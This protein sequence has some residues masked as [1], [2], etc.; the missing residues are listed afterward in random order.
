MSKLVKHLKDA[1]YDLIDGP[2]RNQDLLQLY[3]KR[4]A[5]KI[6]L[7]FDEMLQ[8]FDG[9][10]K[11]SVK[12]DNALSINS[13]MSVSYDFKAGMSAINDSLQAFKIG[14]VSLDAEIKKG[15]EV[16]IS[17]DSSITRVVPTGEI[18]QFLS[19]ARL[20]ASNDRFLKDMNQN[21]LIVVTG[22]V[23]AKNFV[24]EIK[25]ES[26]VNIDALVASAN[27]NGK[28]S[29]QRQSNNS[30]KM[31]SEGDSLIPIAIKANR[32]KFNKDKFSDLHLVSDSRDLFK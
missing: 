27:G 23:F 19:D 6:E 16:N 7:L 11:I 10:T 12:E 22:V 25:T 32:I 29:F 4:P 24:A 17:Y 20:K 3:L 9:D 28:V 1:G 8:A 15:K 31:V 30:I 5:K 21:N 13:S 18:M 26:D 14:N 2:V